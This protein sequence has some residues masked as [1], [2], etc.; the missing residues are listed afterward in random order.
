MS[1]TTVS[2][3]DVVSAA[4]ELIDAA[5]E[6]LLSADVWRMPGQ[7]QSDALPAEQMFRVPRWLRSAYYSTAR[8]FHANLT[9]GLELSYPRSRLQCRLVKRALCGVV[10]VVVR[11]G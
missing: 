1:S 7:M 8:P 4:L 3:P 9:S 10:F 5:T 11:G 6:L 2:P